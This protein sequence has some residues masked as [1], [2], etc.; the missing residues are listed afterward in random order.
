MNYGEL[1]IEIVEALKPLEATIPELKVLEIPEN[2]AGFKVP[3]TSGRVTVAY[4]SS[5]YVGYKQQDSLP[6]KSLDGVNQ[7]DHTSFAIEIQSRRLRGADGIYTI[8][9][10]IRKLLLGYRPLRGFMDPIR[11]KEFKFE[12]FENGVWT[13]MLTVE[14]AGHIVQDMTEGTEGGLTEVSFDQN[15]Y[16][17]P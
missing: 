15:Y 7:I 4:T 6:S 11:Y 1:E 5:D 2:E 12:S 9:E 16:T 13:F 17:N 14:T 8:F 3:Y 10:E